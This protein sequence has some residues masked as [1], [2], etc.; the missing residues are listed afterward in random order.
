M[1]IQVASVARPS[2]GSNAEQHAGRGGHAL[3]ALEAEE[4]RPQVA[5]EG[6]QP[7]QRDRALA[8]PVARSVDAVTSNTGT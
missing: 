3:A 6:R 7:D 2:S 8:E 5:E 4:H 1:T